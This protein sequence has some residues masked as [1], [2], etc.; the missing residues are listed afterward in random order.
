M[1]RKRENFRL[2][3][4]ADD[5]AHLRLD[6]GEDAAA[7]VLLVAG[8]GEVGGDHL[9]AGVAGQPARRLVAGDL[10]AEGDQPLVGDDL[11][12]PLLFGED[13]EVHLARDVQAARLGD[14]AGQAHLL[15]VQED[16]ADVIGLKFLLLREDALAGEGAHDA[17]GA[18]VAHDP[19]AAGEI[20]QLH[21]RVQREVRRDDR[22]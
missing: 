15:A 3:P 21:G 6:A 1:G 11:V 17:H 10:G 20:A 8:R 18:A 9:G 14:D 13:G 12:L 19:V 5:A 2:F 4:A 7:A 22:G 16:V